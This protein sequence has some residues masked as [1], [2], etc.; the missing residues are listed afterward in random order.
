MPSDTDDRYEI[1]AEFAGQFWVADR[2]DGGRLI[3]PCTRLEDARLIVDAL[4]GQWCMDALGNAAI[5][6][7]FSE[8]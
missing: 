5:E 1:R 4:N 6:Y 8:G 3:A 2:E 7:E